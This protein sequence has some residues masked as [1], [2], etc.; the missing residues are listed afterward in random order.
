MTILREFILGD[1]VIN[2]HDPLTYEA[3]TLQGEIW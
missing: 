2:S 1:D 3:L